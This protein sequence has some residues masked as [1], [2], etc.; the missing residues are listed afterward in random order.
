MNR[1]NSNVHSGERILT[2]FIPRRHHGYP[3]CTSFRQRE[4]WNWNTNHTYQF[5]PRLPAQ[6]KCRTSSRLITATYKRSKF[7]TWRTRSPYLRPPDTGWPSCTPTH[8]VPILVAFYDMHGLQW[9]CSV[10]PATTRDRKPN[11]EH[12]CKQYSDYTSTKRKQCIWKDSAVFWEDNN[13]RQ[14]EVKA[15]EEFA[16]DRLWRKLRQ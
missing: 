10:I 1:I 3:F 14:E 15:T 4:R 5:V 11:T 12:E 9:D 8:W 2:S 6:L 7:F 16:V 13:Y